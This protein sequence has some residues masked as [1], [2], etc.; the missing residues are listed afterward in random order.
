MAMRAL[1]RNGVRGLTT[2]AAATPGLRVAGARFLAS[3]FGEPDAE[4]MKDPAFQAKIMALLQKHP[5]LQNKL[6]EI[7]MIMQAR[8]VKPDEPSKAQMEE[9]M[10]D[11]DV[12]EKFTSLQQII[13]E[14]NCESE[15]MTLFGMMGFSPAQTSSALNAGM[16]GGDKKDGEG[17]TS[18]VDPVVKY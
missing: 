12:R 2:R 1:C 11:K 16:L 4:K 9:I 14:E 5:R 3:P 15:M 17:K 13:R 8:G 10:Q 18:D 7:G 6:T